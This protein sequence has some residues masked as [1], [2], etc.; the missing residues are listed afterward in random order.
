[1]LKKCAECGKDFE[2]RNNRQKYCK[3]PHYR[4][5]PICET[6][7]L[8]TGR[9]KACS[10][11]CGVKYSNILKE[12][13]EGKN[14]GFTKK[15]KYCQKEFITSSSGKK[16]CQN[17]H[18][19][20]CSHCG[21]FFKTTLKKELK[22]HYYC[23]KPECRAE[24]IK[25]S[26][27]KKYGVENVSHLSEVK[28]K[29][30]DSKNN[31]TVEE[32]I[33][34]RKKT[35]NTNLKKYGVATPLQNEEIYK[36]VVETNRERYGVDNVGQNKDFQDKV[37]RTNKEKYGVE[38]SF[39]AE[40]V[41]NKIKASNLDKYG[42]EYSLQNPD[43]REKGRRTILDLYGVDNVGS[44]EI[45]KEKIKNT[46]K[47]K[48]GV[49]YSFQSE[50]VKNKIKKTNRDRYG[51]DNPAQNKDIINKMKKSN[52]KKYGVDNVAK[53][54]ETI[55]KI[56]QTSLRKYGTNNPAERN[57]LHYKDYLDFD[58]FVKNNPQTIR[59]LAKYFNVN[60]GTIRR[61]VRDRQLD[62]YVIGRY[63]SSMLEENFAHYF[64][65][66][67]ISFIRNDRKILKGKELDFYFPE[68]N[69]AVEISPSV[70]HHHLETR[71]FGYKEDKN[72]H[73]NKF[74]ECSNLGID[75]ITIFDWHDWDKVL[76][77][78][79]NKLI[80][81]V[82]IYAR[83]TFYE[84]FNGKH[85]ELRTLIK[86]WHILGMSQN[87]PV[88]KYSVLKNK[89]NGKILG[90]AA[91]SKVNSNSSMIELKRL[92][93]CPGFNIVG[94]FSKIMKNFIKNNKEF[95]KIM[96]FSDCDLG[97]GLVYEKNGFNLT[98]ESK[99]NLNYYDTFTNTL[100]KRL[101]LVLMG[102]DR[103]LKDFPGYQ[104][105]GVGDNLPSNDEIILSYGFL[106][107]YDCGYRK[108][109]KIL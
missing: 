103:I 9:N 1:M 8:W 25:Q 56:R 102:A 60:E 97:Q 27:M 52:I 55:E 76:E 26:N 79:K 18:P 99:P 81:S 16:Y 95:T 46:N 105:V 13:G 21:E 85:S 96:T 48:Y 23:S 64:E 106:P 50:E 68:F 65:N 73:K 38:Y 98:V 53:S 5:C 87:A 66:L 36:K 47:E 109:I 82:S 40:E 83:K 43:V 67:G 32:K 7:F 33:K 35:A 75:L 101:T 17:P 44:S 80:K 29:I 41:K 4:N 39:Q 24:A 31:L 11:A 86:N 91:W 3:E 28:Q 92:V 90:I 61:R 20:K 54:K 2:A 78:I 77:M 62:S 93:F 94:G 14:K 70:T 15:C 58:N 37:K 59:E 51:V 10:N 34:I 30:S 100:V 63:K 42:V 84:E 45:I 22:E 57:I 88:Y 19:V 6:P 49:D 12:K 74:L 107:V 69:L 89:E 72:Y 71:E 108:W 104:K